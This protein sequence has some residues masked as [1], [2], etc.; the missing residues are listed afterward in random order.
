[1]AAVEVPFFRIDDG[2][3]RTE[4]AEGRADRI[5]DGEVGFDDRRRVAAAARPTTAVDTFSLPCPEA[6]MVTV[7]FRTLDAPAPKAFTS[8][9][10][11]RGV[12]SS[13]ARQAP[14]M[15]LRRSAAVGFSAAA[16]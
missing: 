5:G 14:D 10:D 7:T 11:V 3:G 9:S 15:C 8:R 2:D 6:S 1:M 13:S 16:G 12:L 4:P